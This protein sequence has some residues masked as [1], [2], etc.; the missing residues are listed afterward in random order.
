MYCSAGGKHNWEYGL[1]GYRR[2]TKCQFSQYRV[3]GEWEDEKE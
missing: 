3:G 1:G 2:C